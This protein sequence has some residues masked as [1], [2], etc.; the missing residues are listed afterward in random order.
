MSTQETNRINGDIPNE[1][2]KKFK[3]KLIQENKEV[4]EWLEESIT[5]YVSKK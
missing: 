2:Y 3:I 4:K 1:L 5:H